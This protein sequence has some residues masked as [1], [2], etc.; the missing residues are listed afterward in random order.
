MSSHSSASSWVRMKPALC[1]FSR[2]SSLGGADNVRTVI[3][4]GPEQF[5][6]RRYFAEGVRGIDA[7]Y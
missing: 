4:I 1:A 2:N 5:A 7:F 3:L 6:A